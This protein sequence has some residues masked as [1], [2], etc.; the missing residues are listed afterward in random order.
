MFSLAFVVAHLV[1]FYLTFRKL[2]SPTLFALVMLIISVSSSILYF[3]SQTYTEAMYM[4]LQ[5]L[6]IFL[7]IRIYQKLQ[8]DSPIPL[9]KANPAMAGACLFCFFVK[10]H[11]KYWH[12][13]SAG[14]ADLSCMGK[15]ISFFAY[16]ILI[17]PCFFHSF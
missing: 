1:L 6:S 7:F 2:V 14:D 17:I 10:S 15:K 13:G 11:P 4:F 12:C 5:S 8:S 16:P 3:A 9:R